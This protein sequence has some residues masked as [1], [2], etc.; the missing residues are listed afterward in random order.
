MCVLLSL[1]LLTTMIALKSTDESAMWMVLHEIIA[2]L[3]LFLEQQ[4][5]IPILASRQAA[6]YISMEFLLFLCVPPGDPNVASFKA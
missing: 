4:D 5:Q 3:S 1:L 6:Q 2:V